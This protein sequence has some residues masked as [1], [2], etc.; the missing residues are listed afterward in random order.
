LWGVIGNVFC[1]VAQNLKPP[2]FPFSKAWNADMQ[3]FLQ[4]P[5]GA[6]F[7]E[8][9]DFGRLSFGVGESAAAL[10][11]GLFLLV[12]ISFFAA[13]HYQQAFRPA[14]TA[15]RPDLWQTILKWVPWGLLLAF[16]AKI[17]TYENG[18]QLASYYVLLFPLLL[19]SAGQSILV[20]QRWWMTLAILVLALSAGLLVISRDR[21]LFPAQ[22]MVAWLEAKF[23]HSKLV[24]NIQT[25]YAETPAFE[26][27]RKQI[28]GILPKDESVLGYASGIDCP[29]GSSVWLPY[30]RRRVI[31]VLPGDTAK[32]MEQAGIH[33]V[34]IEEAY[35]K[36]AQSTPQQWLGQYNAVLIAQWEFLTDPYQP[37]EN[38]YL[39]HLQN[40]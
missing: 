17:G 25:T 20:R 18:R 35:L 13:R 24:S 30:G 10:G 36:Q 38:L 37:P 5:L 19:S 33:D 8:F 16:M 2:V 34:V 27:Q 6:H 32:Q 39:M 7:R 22:T 15:N 40:P 9:E 3:L 29:A 21:P 28:M 31:E 26:A 12:A 14:E 23:P 4:T 1:L 11:A